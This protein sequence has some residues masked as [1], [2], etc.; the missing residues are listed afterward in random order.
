MLKSSVR[1]THNAFTDLLHRHGDRTLA[2]QFNQKGILTGAGLLP[3]ILKNN[4]HVFIS[5]TLI[6][7]KKVD[8]SSKKLNRV[9]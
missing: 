6:I 3:D 5:L 9:R 1:D 8:W 2:T 7:V 4:V